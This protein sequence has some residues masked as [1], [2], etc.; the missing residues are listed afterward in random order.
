[1]AL[2]IQIYSLLFS[3]IFGVVFNLLLN[4]FNKFN[5]GKL[6]IRIIFSL[7]FVFTLA[8]LYFI[9]LLHINNGYLHVYFLIFIMVGYIIVDFIK[10][11]YFTHKKK[12]K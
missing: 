11:F 1:M 3:L 7:L 10:S 4:W 5:N 12:K 8:L 6:L 9:G 2:N